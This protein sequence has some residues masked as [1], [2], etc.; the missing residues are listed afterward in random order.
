MCRGRARLL[1]VGGET[2][3]AGKRRR[4]L[5]S[6]RLPRSLRPPCPPGPLTPLSP[7][8]TEQNG[9]RSHLSPNARGRSAK[10]YYPPVLLP[11]TFPFLASHSLPY[12]SSLGLGGRDRKARVRAA[13]LWRPISRPAPGPRV[14]TPINRH[15]GASNCHLH[16][17]LR[18]TWK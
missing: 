6:R 11:F 13:G 7:A 18:S 10:P 1:M 3:K 17:H 4:P 14:N 15:K 2:K 8:C 9:G 16:P 5:C 12:P